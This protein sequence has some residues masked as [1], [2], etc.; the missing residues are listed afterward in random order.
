MLTYLELW[1][2][3]GG[4]KNTTKAMIDE[5]DFA[6]FLTLAA[7]IKDSDEFYDLIEN[8]DGRPWLLVKG[9]PNDRVFAF[10]D[11]F[12]CYDDKARAKAV[13]WVLKELST[14]GYCADMWEEGSHAIALPGYEKDAIRAI[15]AIEA[16]V[17]A[18]SWGF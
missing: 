17:D 4:L 3:R 10:M 14:K 9:D 12:D 15:Q 1:Q 7:D 13:K 18:D 11:L 6:L 2:D 5:T 16:E 8:D